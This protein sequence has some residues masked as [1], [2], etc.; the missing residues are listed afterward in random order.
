VY[1]NSAHAFIDVAGGGDGHRLVRAREAHHP[2][3]RAAMAT[4]A[5]HRPQYSGDIAAGNG[6]FVQRHPVG[7]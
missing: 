7:L 2:E 1:A 4:R 5:D 6:G 3:Q